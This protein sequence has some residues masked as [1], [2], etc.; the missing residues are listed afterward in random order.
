M[1]LHTPGNLHSLQLGLVTDNA[2]PED[3]IGRA[4][5]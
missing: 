5:V 1:N 3:Q 2:D 4:H